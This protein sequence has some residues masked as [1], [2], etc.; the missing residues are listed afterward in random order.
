VRPLTTTMQVLAALVTLMIAG[1]RMLLP[2][3]TDRAANDNHR[4]PSFVVRSE[5][6]R[7]SRWC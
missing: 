3:R 1:L 4:E 7:L 2:R 6:L 5:E